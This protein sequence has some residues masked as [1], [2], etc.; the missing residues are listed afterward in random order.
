MA[1]T[2]SHGGPTIYRSPGPSRQVLVGTI[3][4]VACIERELGGAGWR[5]A[6]RALAGKHIHALLHEP[7]SGA[8][9][10]G[11]KSGSIFASAD[12]GE[13]WERRDAGLTQQNVYSLACA[14]MPDGVRVFAGTEP[15][16]L[17]YS[18]DL[19]RSWAELPALRS[20][21]TSKWSFPAPPHVAHTK[22]INF[23]PND[24]SML[25][26]GV[27][28]GGLIHSADAGKTFRAIP[29]MDDDVHRTLFN[30]LNP[31]R[32]YITT[33]IGM[34]V[35]SD[36]ARTWEQW[37]DLQHEIGGYPDL[38][39]LHPRRPELMFVASAQKGP[40]S[41][42]RE[43]FAGSR[44][45]RSLDGGKTWEVLLDHGLPDRLR[46]AFEAM[47]LEDWGESFSLFAATATG[48]VWCS[49]DGGARWTEVVTGMAPISKGDHYVAFVTA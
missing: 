47:C 30:P 26:I 22:H 5:V 16:H 36:G 27:E 1:I 42:R 39:V 33:G 24:P 13:T 49:D 35:S 10:A 19:G 3:D 45:S 31:D 21:D 46:T 6:R 20:V 37:T 44:I 34:Y 14:R 32:I 28:Q 18:D 40:G 17:F 2:L 41:W 29:G 15:A 43:H 8:L 11:V 25:F 12:G 7:E 23:H 48:E 4:G 38:L 9:F